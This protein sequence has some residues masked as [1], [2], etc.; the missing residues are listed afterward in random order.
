MSDVRPS[1]YVTSAEYQAARLREC[2]DDINGMIMDEDIPFQRL[3]I[4]YL[5]MAVANLEI[6]LIMSNRKLNKRR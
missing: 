6:A 2:I 3:V 5:T 1:N 4:P